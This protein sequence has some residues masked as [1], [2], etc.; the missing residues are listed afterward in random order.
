VKNPKPHLEGTENHKRGFDV[1]G[2]A[3][4][5]GGGSARIVFQVPATI[6]TMLKNGAWN[7][8]GRPYELQVTIK[9]PGKKEVRG[10]GSP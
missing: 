10:K 9:K 6:L 2:G 7:P 4:D 8:Q 3:K 1:G 5:C